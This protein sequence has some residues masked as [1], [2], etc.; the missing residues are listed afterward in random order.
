M[1]PVEW[2]ADELA[3]HVGGARFQWR[4]FFLGFQVGRIPP[5]LTEEKVRACVTNYLRGIGL[6]RRKTNDKE[7]KCPAG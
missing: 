1:T 7:T 4:S 5:P 3:R 2:V 6:K